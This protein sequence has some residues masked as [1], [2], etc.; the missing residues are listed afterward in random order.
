MP[1]SL[2]Q[3]ADEPLYIL[4]ALWAQQRGDWISRTDISETFGIKGPSRVFPGLL[5]LPAEPAH[6]LRSSCC[7]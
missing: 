7:P 4:I 1:P 5:Y 3:Y 2:Q 6:H